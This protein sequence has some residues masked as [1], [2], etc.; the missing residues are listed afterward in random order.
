MY[1]NA[2]APHQREILFF[3]KSYYLPPVGDKTG[4]DKPGGEGRQAKF[5]V[6]SLAVNE[7]NLPLRQEKIKN[8]PVFETI[9]KFI[10]AL[11]IPQS[12]GRT[13]P[14]GLPGSRP[15]VLYGDIDER[16]AVQPFPRCQRQ[17]V[18]LF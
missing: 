17:R 11:A 7:Y 12:S 1:K 13:E 10:S 16:P 15:A 3:P 5:P 9:E 4:V 8:T 2:R 18:R 6:F 14:V